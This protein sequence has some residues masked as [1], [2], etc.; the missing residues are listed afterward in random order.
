MSVAAIA[1]DRRRCAEAARIAELRE[2]FASLTSRERE[3]MG[4]VVAG[5]GTSGSQAS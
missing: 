5:Q 1:L 2:R 3:I 4:F